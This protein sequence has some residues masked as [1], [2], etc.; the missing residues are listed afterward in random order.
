MLREMFRLS[1]VFFLCL[2]TPS[3]K[4]SAVFLAPPPLGAREVTEC[5]ALLYLS[6]FYVDIM[7]RKKIAPDKYEELALYFV[8]KKRAKLASRRLRR[9]ISFFLQNVI[10]AVA[11]GCVSLSLSPSLS[12]SLSLSARIDS[13]H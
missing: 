12:L 13:H 2:D 11:V 3:L 6:S 5:G 1:R 7:E 4:A 10:A 9:A 8:L